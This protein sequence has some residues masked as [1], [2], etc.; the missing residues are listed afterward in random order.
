M[1]SQNTALVEILIDM[2]KLNSR[3]S[4]T[5]RKMTRNERKVAKEIIPEE[6]ICNASGLISDLILDYFTIKD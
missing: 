1:N 5:C 4:D 3:F 2:Q 6:A